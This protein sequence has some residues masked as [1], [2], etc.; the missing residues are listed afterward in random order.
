MSDANS[1]FFASLI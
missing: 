1:V